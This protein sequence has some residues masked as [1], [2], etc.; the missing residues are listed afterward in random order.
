MDWPLSGFSL[1]EFGVL[2]EEIG[3]ESGSGASL[4]PKPLCTSHSTDAGHLHAGGG[5][6]LESCLEGD[7]TIECNAIRAT[8]GYTRFMNFDGHD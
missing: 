4:E 7:Q 5:L 6:H 3:Q 1:L 8:V 2:G